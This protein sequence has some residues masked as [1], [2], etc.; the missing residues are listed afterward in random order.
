[1]GIAVDA[2]G[3]AYV[4]GVTYS[5]DF[6]TTEGAFQT[7][8]G[9]TSRKRGGPYSSS[10][11]TGDAFIVKI[12]EGLPGITLT[13]TGYK[14][15]GLQKV[16]L[17]WSGLTPPVG[18]LR[19][20]ELKKWTSNAGFYTDDIGQKGGGTYQYQVCEQEEY[21]VICSEKVEVIF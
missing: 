14:V 8:L 16:D 11:P 4:T 21:P 2:D 12:V 9:R 15:K 6:P 19:D 17:E 10:D 1:L 13:A 18:I 5:S 20:G 3:N 7:R